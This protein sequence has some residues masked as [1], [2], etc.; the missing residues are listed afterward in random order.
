MTTQTNSKPV[1]LQEMMAISL[2][3]QAQIETLTAELNA[4][5][6]AV[7]KPA[8]NVLTFKPSKRQLIDQKDPS[9][10]KKEPSGCLSLYGMGRNPA[11][12]WPDQWLRIW[13][14]EEIRKGKQAIVDGAD[15]QE[16]GMDRLTWHTPEAKAACLA[17]LASQGFVKS[18]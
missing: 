10:G 16:D 12:H 13:S 7:A 9:K 6:A 18:K 4:A 3:M 2:K 1:S 14:D 8:T 11:S 17:L 5:K 15:E